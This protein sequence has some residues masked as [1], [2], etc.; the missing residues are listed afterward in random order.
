MRDDN[1]IPARRLPLFDAFSHAYE[2]RN[3][4]ICFGLEWL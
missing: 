1:P 3:Q 4:L 2:H